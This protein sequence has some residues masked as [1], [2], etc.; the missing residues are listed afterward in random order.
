MKPLT[1]DRI[2]AEY[3]VLSGDIE[4]AQREMSKAE[5]RLGEL[6]R[7]CPHPTRGEGEMP[8]GMTP[9]PNQCPDCGHFEEKD[10]G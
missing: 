9:Y 3:Q 6:H 4:D 1:R 8:D 5:E 10:S 2:R 7:D